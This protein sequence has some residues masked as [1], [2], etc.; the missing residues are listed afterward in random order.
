MQVQGKI[1]YLPTP[2]LGVFYP[3]G[4]ETP[5]HRQTEWGRLEMGEQSVP[6]MFLVRKQ[7]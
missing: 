7:A 2:L 6:K 3:T 4:K 1:S 5:F